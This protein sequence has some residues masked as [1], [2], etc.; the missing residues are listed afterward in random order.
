MLGVN[1]ELRTVAA[2]IVR[3]VGGDLHVANVDSSFGTP[4]LMEQVLS[5]TSEVGGGMAT[6]YR[7]G[8]RESEVDDLFK[9]YADAGVLEHAQ[10]HGGNMMAPP[11]GNVKEGQ[12]ALIAETFGGDA[13]GPTEYRLIFDT[14]KPPASIKDALTAIDELVAK[15]HAQG[16]DPTG[17]AAGFG[18]IA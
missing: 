17:G 9:A 6:T 11:Y 3:H 5:S 12:S 4:N 7:L 15:A 14:D 8:G 2:G 10:P 16:P 18:G 13:G 1:T